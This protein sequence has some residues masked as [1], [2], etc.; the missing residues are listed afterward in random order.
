MRTNEEIVGDYQRKPTNKVFNELL[1]QNMGLI[2]KLA[3][4]YSSV[5]AEREDLEQEA[6]LVML[7][8]AQV[9]DPAHECKFA[10]FLTKAIKNR[11]STYH[12]QNPDPVNIVELDCAKNVQVKQR[13]PGEIIDLMDAIGS[14]PVWRRNAI[15]KVYFS[16][17]LPSR[18]DKQIALT[19]KP[20]LR[21]FLEKKPTPYASRSKRP[22]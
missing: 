4:E 17:G 11:F 1:E 12:K 6:T 18:S 21:Q 15:T 22:E 13:H 7:K 14:L 10:T 20:L 5:G 16:K 9:F 8:I 19:T 2:S 3:F